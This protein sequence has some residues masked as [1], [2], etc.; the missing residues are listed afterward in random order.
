MGCS[1][2]PTGHHILLSDNIRR[3][4]SVKQI[5]VQPGLFVCENISKFQEIYRI[6]TVL[7]SGTY[8]EVRL[9]FHR[10]S[11]ERRAVK[12]F[13]K[14]LYQSE[15]KK[16]SLISEITTLK[17]LDHPNII[18]VYEFF[19]DERRLYI[20]ME[21]CSGGELFG[22]I[23]KRKSFNEINA[24]QIMYQIFSALAY[25]HGKNIVHRDLKPENILLEDQHDVLNIKVIDFGTAVH[26]GEG[27]TIRGMVGTPYYLA[28]EVIAADYDC[29]ADTW[30]AGVIL[31]ILLSG[32]PP[33]PGTSDAEIMAKIG[34][35]VFNYSQEVWG[36]ISLD[37]VDLINAL[38]CPKNARISAAQALNHKWVDHKAFRPMCNEDI[39]NGVLHKLSVFHS[40]NKLRDAVH[41]FITTQCVSMKETRILREVFKTIDKNGDGKLSI[42]ELIEQYSHTMAIEEATKEAE[43]I[44]KEVDTD[45]N[46]FI[47]YSEF[48]KAN[49]DI[50][51]VMS[52]E[53]LKSAFRMFDKDNSGTISAQELKQVLQGDMD[54]EDNV[55]QEIIQ[56]VD[57]NGDGEIDLHEFQDIVLSK[58]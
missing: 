42:E 16:A 54:S 36:K 13:K 32:Q 45:N 27:K 58:A 37:A 56:L 35:G 21:Y 51:K 41:T 30:S 52:N 40:T 1:I 7:G 24:A 25:M 14:Q 43:R 6:S 34:M 22:E 49:L 50:R 9:C 39:L 19:E 57:Q 11:N 47:D 38:L 18:R 48:L 53:N 55:W 33:F 10:E 46:G 8:G 31:Y 23:V 28:P 4:A 15:I 3:I 5:I 17:S 26:V 12:I 20:V 29:L 44:M 2:K